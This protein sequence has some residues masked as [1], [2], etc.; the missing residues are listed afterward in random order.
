LVYSCVLADVV[1]QLKD[2]HLRHHW[3]R[4][5]RLFLLGV[6]QSV[7]QAL[8]LGM[9]LVVLAV[10]LMGLAMVVISL[11]IVHTVCMVEGCTVDLA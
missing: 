6:L 8:C 10:V 5:L 11:D 2:L 4:L 7:D 1:S 3:C 9:V